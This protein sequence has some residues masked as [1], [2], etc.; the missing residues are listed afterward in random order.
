VVIPSRKNRA[1]P[2][3]GRL[4]GRTVEVRRRLRDAG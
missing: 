4:T 2:R 3:I 1:G